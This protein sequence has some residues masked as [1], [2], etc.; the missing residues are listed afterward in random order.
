MY[1]DT[2]LL[3]L[4]LICYQ[5]PYVSFHSLVSLLLCLEKIWLQGND[6]EGTVPSE[7]CNLPAAGLDFRT[8]CG[9]GNVECECC[10]ECY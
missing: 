2:V 10:T 9:T 5:C 6:L 7:L 8:D 1:T 3:L 4:L